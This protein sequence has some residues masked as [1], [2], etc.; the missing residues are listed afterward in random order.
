MKTETIRGKIIAHYYDYP[1]GQNNQYGAG[2]WSRHASS[3]PRPVLVTVTPKRVEVSGKSVYLDGKRKLKVTLIRQ[4][5][6]E[7]LREDYAM[8][9]IKADLA[10]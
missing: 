9:R 7:V 1:T 4:S 2:G 3:R 8:D 6:G 5:T 10:S